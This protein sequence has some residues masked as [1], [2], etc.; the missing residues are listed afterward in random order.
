M[1]TCNKLCTCVINYPKRTIYIQFNIR[2][3]FCSLNPEMDH[4]Y[5]KEL[6]CIRLYGNP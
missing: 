6:S 2:K 5:P 3:Q 1:H 4:V